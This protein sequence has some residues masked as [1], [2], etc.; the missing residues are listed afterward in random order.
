MRTLGTHLGLDRFD[1]PLG[2]DRVRFSF[3]RLRQVLLEKRTK[4][5][6]KMDGDAGVGEHGAGEN[7]AQ[8]SIW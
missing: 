8:V 3:V 4:L 6:R 2:L 5:G 1:V 7:G